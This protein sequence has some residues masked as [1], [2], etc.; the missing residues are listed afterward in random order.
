MKIR[1]V[2]CLPHILQLTDSTGPCALSETELRMRK[3]RTGD[4]KVTPQQT[5]GRA[6]V[7]FTSQ[8]SFGTWVSL[9]HRSQ[10][11]TGGAEARGKFID[12]GWDR[13]LVLQA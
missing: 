8:I 12:K 13:K 1:R 6:A 10:G 9:A 11:N 3:S 5:L 7:L 2:F 4:K